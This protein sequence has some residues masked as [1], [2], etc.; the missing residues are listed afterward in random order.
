MNTQ[1]K[2]RIF[3]LM[4]RMDGV[5]EISNGCNYQ[6]LLSSDEETARDYLEYFCETNLVNA[7]ILAGCVRAEYEKLFLEGKAIPSDILNYL[8]SVQ[9][10]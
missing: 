4:H 9:T 1:I 5:W 10:K 2:K 8:K 3:A 6:S 7:D